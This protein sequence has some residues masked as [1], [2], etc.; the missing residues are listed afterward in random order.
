MRYTAWGETRCSSGNVPTS[1]RFTGQREDGTIGL[2]FYKA[3]YYDPV[4][5]RF[6]Q[7]DTIVPEPGNPQDLNRYVY[8]RNNPLKCTDPTGY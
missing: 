1:Y 6:I 7:P 8:V 2:Y 4:I 3:R 5:G